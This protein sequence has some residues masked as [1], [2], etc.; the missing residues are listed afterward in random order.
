MTCGNPALM[1]IQNK[2]D[3][4]WKKIARLLL[5]A[6]IEKETHFHGMKGLGAREQFGKVIRKQN[7]TNTF[8]SSKITSINK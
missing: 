3:L 6:N 8:V 7:R 5:S 4:Q 2:L 1:T